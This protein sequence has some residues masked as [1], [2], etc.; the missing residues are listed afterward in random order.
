LRTYDAAKI[1]GQT[2]QAIQLMEIAR[3]FQIADLSGRESMIPFDRERANLILPGLG[4]LLAV[5]GIMK[6]DAM[7][8]SCGGLRFGAALYPQKIWA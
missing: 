7:V 5:L 1:H 3:R 4:I 2:L 6:K 8:V